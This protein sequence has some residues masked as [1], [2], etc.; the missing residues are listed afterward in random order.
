MKA[1][2][3]TRGRVRRKEAAPRAR[4]PVHQWVGRLEHRS[5]SRGGAMSGSVVKW[6]LSAH[7]RDALTERATRAAVHH[8]ET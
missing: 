1:K 7:R 2:T 3:V 6:Y 5:S 8:Q 4:M